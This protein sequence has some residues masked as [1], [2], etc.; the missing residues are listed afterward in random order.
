LDDLHLS[1][2]N[3]ENLPTIVDMSQN[4]VQVPKLTGPPQ[5]IDAAAAKTRTRRRVAPTADNVSRLPARG[6]MSSAHQ[7]GGNPR[8]T[9]LVFFPELTLA[10]GAYDGNAPV[11]LCEVSGENGVIAKGSQIDGLAA[12]C[13]VNQSGARRRNQNKGP[14]GIVALGKLSRAIFHFEDDRRGALGFTGEKGIGE[15]VGDRHG[16]FNGGCRKAAPPGNRGRNR[17]SGSTYDIDGDNRPSRPIP[18]RAFG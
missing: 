8:A 13:F 5:E 4:E 18:A 12:G 10:S 15:S 16:G 7:R 1:V 9:D 2:P 3:F 14:V 11:T 6:P 17:C